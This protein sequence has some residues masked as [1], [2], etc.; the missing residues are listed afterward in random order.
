M[1]ARYCGVNCAINIL[2]PEFLAIAFTEKE[3][4]GVYT[5]N[6]RYHIS[7]W[8]KKEKEVTHNGPCAP[9]AFPFR[10]PNGKLSH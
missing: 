7:S 9:I 3:K 1:W 8:K 5:I 10:P 4:T 6:A 2:I